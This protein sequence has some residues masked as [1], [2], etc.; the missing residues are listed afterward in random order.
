MD[1]D[2]AT[3]AASSPSH[4]PRTGLSLPFGFPLN[5][6]SRMAAGWLPHGR[7]RGHR[8]WQGPGDLSHSGARRFV[9]QADRDD[10]TGSKRRHR[11]TTEQAARKR[12][13]MLLNADMDIGA[14]GDRVAVKV[15]HTAGPPPAAGNPLASSVNDMD[16]WDIATVRRLTTITVR[17]ALVSK[18]VLSPDRV[19]AAVVVLGAS[20]ARRPRRP[21]Q[22]SC[23]TSPPAE[24]IRALERSDDLEAMTDGGFGAPAF[25]RDGKSAAAPLHRA[26]GILGRDDRP[27]ALLASRYRASTWRASRSAPTERGWRR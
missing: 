15:R 25:S 7:L 9:R 16:I 19:H 4:R 11:E 26:I 17:G 24:M 18:V 21:A 14:A 3:A 27:R 22:S 2:L 13:H 23:T 8:R 5:F 6:R 12:S 1:R 20:S 10:C